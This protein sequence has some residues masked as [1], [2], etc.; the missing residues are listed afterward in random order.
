MRPAV[1]DRHH[2]RIAA[3]ASRDPDIV[4]LPDVLLD[5]LRNAIGFD[6]ICA[7]TFDPVT[8]LPTSLRHV[9]VASLGV[10]RI[11]LR[12]WLAVTQS[13]EHGRRMQR[14]ARSRLPAEILGRSGG[15]QPEHSAVWQ[16]LHAPA[17][18]HSLFAMLVADGACYGF[19]NFLRASSR[20]GFTAEHVEM[21]ASI[22]PDLAHAARAVV[23]QPGTGY[24][25]VPAH[26]GVIVVDEELAITSTSAEARH[27]LADLEHAP[28]MVCPVVHPL[29]VAALS[30]AKAAT[31]VRV[32]SRSGVWLQVSATPLD[33]SGSATSPRTVAVVIGPASAEQL[34]PVMSRAYGL[35][36]R[37]QEIAVL[38]GGGHTSV[39]IARSLR[40]SPYTVND[41]LKNVFRKV[42]VSRRQELAIALGCA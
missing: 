9:G 29:A 18:V 17:G 3:I 2:R 33:S 34:A 12:E 22:A 4:T 41:H 32:R 39:A 20:P 35:T 19:V 11:R 6:A 16:H 36:G 25:P 38:A 15:S 7:G 26:P 5:A 27:W 24:R 23:R 13:R 28:N 8:L 40:I 30:G 14:L 37:E 21:A 31:A 1:I 10:G 42:G